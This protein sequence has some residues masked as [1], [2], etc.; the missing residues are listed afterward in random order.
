MRGVFKI[1]PSTSGLKKHYKMSRKKL[2]MVTQNMGAGLA[3]ISKDYRTL[4]ANNVLK[5]IF[6]DVE[7]KTCYSTYNHKGEICSGCG[8]RE[9]YEKG[10]DCAVHEQV[11]KDIEGNTIWSEIIATP[12][13][14][15][16]GNITAALELVIPV[17]ER[18]YA[19][20]EKASLEEQLRQSQKME[21]IGN[22][23]GGIA[24]DFNNLL[25][26]IGGTSQLLLLDLKE[27]DP[28]RV[29]IEEIQKAA[30]R[31]ANLTRQLLVFSR[32][33]IIET[34]IL[35]LNTVLRDLEKMG[36]DPIIY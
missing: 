18:K 1:S 11:G 25:T 30:E 12:I 10:S 17:T 2:E 19:E 16:D 21:S 22:L 8:V 14:D 26:V 3:L 31:A 34:Q 20:K 13:K 5:Q 27:G 36:R 4:W 15:Q 23:A 33:Q 9:V 29:N 35:D 32:R 28:L 7:G 6:G 24:H